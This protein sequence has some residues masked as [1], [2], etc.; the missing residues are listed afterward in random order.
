MYINVLNIF[1]GFGISSIILSSKENEFIKFIKGQKRRI[2]TLYALLI[3]S[4]SIVLL[5]IT[6]ELSKS[7]ILIITVLSILQ[8]FINIWEAFLI[9]REKSKIILISNIGYSVAFVLWHLQIKP[10]YNIDDL[11]LGIIIL[12][13]FKFLIY[14]FQR[15]KFQTEIGE[16]KNDFSRQWAFIGF[17]DVVGVFAKWIDKLILIYIITPTEFAIFFNGSI[18]IPVFGILISVI[19]SIMLVE[20]ATKISNK[21]EVVKIFRESFLLLACIVF[22]LFWFLLFYRNELFYVAFGN[23]YDASIPIFLITLLIIPLRINHYGAILQCYNKSNTILKGSILDILIALALMP[24]LYFFFGVIGVALSIV[25]STYFQCFYYINHSAKVL[26]IP[27]FQLV[28]IKSIIIQ[29]VLICIIYL[30]LFFTTQSLN[31]LASLV[32]ET[33]RPWVIIAINLLFY[34][35]KNKL[36]SEKIRVIN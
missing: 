23:K 24:I 15:I 16:I 30:L 3:F 17:N 6:K 11:L 10:L 21:N 8:I 13:L 19:G 26:Q 34:F 28:P 27:V 35:K 25:I 7:T 1:F 22:P 9:K 14:F 18:E 5:L 36:F 32:I 31:L 20:I 33:L 29:F 2:F 4:V 12:T